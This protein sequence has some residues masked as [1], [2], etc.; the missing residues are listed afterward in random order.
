MAADIEGLIR[1]DGHTINVTFP[2]DIT[3]ATV[4][5][6]VNSESDPA[7]DDTAAITKTITE[8]ADATAGKTTIVLDPEDT[9][10]MEAGVYFYDLQLKTSGG[11][12][13]SV[14]QAKFILA[15]DITRRTS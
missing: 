3:G 7:S 6:T 14:P 12:I 4:F 11:V 5:F 10:E 8:H 1:G 2:T 9:A 13:S 15:A